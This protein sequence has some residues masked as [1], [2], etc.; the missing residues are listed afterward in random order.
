MRDRMEREMRNEGK[1][2]K[3]E[4]RDSTGEKNET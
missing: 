4:V 2:G 3:R 1:D